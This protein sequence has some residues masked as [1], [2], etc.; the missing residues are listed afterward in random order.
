[1]ED[2][3]ILTRKKIR[4]KLVL[5]CSETDLWSKMYVENEWGEFGDN[6][7]MN[8]IAKTKRIGGFSLKYT[9]KSVCVVACKKRY[10]V[11]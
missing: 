1:M 2:S 7:A 9:R 10:L 5:K 3:R 4:N 11:N 8:N 6:I